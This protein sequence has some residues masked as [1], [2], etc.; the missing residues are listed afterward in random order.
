MKRVT[1]IAAAVTV[2]AAVVAGAGAAVA[3]ETRTA[4]PMS[5]HTG[6]TGCFSWSWSDGNVSTTVYYHNTCGRSAQIG[7]RWRFDSDIQWYT[8]GANQKGHAS[9]NGAVMSIDSD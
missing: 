5:L 6:S 3:A 1:K 7:I 9:G 2:G 8:V 4:Q